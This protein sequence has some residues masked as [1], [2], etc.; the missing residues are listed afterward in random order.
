M[1]HEFPPKTA[2]DNF[3]VDRAVLKSKLLAAD[4]AKDA[5]AQDSL[6]QISKA[7][8]GA[9]AAEIEAVITA[10]QELMKIS[11]GRLDDPDDLERLVTSAGVL[12]FRI[13]VEASEISATDKTAALDSLRSFGPDRIVE[14]NGSHARWFPIEKES[15]DNFT[16]PDPAK[17]I[18]VTGQERDTNDTYVL[19]YD[20]Q[21]RTDQSHTL[22]HADRP[23][24]WSTKAETPRSD[25][26][27]PR[28]GIMMPFSMDPALC[29]I[30]GRADQQ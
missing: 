24:Q 18:F 25:P 20:D 17:S 23:R 19:L 5:K 29:Q 6:E 30:H 10:H 13:A 21:G 28:G 26:S 16:N 1:T 27:D 22:T 2:V 7:F 3:N 15:L 12:D 9:A 11:Q 8:S 14:A 4:D